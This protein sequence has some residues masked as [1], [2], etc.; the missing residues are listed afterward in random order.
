V[1]PEPLRVAMLLSG[2]GRTLQNLLEHVATRSLPVRV[3]AVASNKPGVRGLEIA[4]SAGLPRRAF[5]IGD[6]E[7]RPA[8]DAAMLR[9]LEGYEPEIFVL[10]GYLALLDL[11]AAKGKPVLNIHPALLPAHGGKGLYGDRVHAAVLAAG[12]GVTGCTVHLVNAKFDE[13]RVLRQ[14]QVPVLEDDDV[15]TLADRVFRA[16]CQL[17]PEVLR[18]IAGGELI[19]D[20]LARDSPQSPGEP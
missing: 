1:I 4:A 9:W 12:E 8:R 15:R 13:G 17:Y 7:T 3:V 18:E 14:R 2:T 19:L 6:F 16:E 20:G 5:Q 11:A 10:A